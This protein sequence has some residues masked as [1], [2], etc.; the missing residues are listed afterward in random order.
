MLDKLH[1]HRKN[2][3]V[4]HWIY[5][6]VNVYLGVC[7]CVCSMTSFCFV[8]VYFLS[9]AH[10]HANK[11][12][13]VMCNALCI[14]RQTCFYPVFIL[15]SAERLTPV[16]FPSFCNSGSEVKWST[17][18]ANISQISA[19]SPGCGQSCSKARGPKTYR[20]PGKPWLSGRFL[21]CQ[22]GF[23][24]G[25]FVVCQACFDSFVATDQGCCVRQQTKPVCRFCHLG[26]FFFLKTVNKQRHQIALC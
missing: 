24:L 20:L 23:R 1:N 5:G 9:Q 22:C 19:L 8:A 10:V 12:R 16:D 6:P 13:S 15:D 7:L 3:H 26:D 25:F 2:Q 4:S 21:V 11:S 18:C 17:A 14:L